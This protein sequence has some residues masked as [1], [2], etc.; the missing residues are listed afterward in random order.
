MRNLISSATDTE[1][2][3][4]IQSLSAGNQLQSVKLMPISQDHMQ[5]QTISQVQQP[6]M[7]K[8]VLPQ[9]NGMGLNTS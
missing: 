1:I 6:V 9:T 5:T 8:P 7:M 2:L 4:A 3:N